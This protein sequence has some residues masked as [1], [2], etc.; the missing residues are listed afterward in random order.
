MAK[1]DWNKRN[2]DQKA[3]DNPSR[4]KKEQNAKRSKEIESGMNAKQKLQRKKA[5]EADRVKT[6]LLPRISKK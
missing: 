2:S 1:Y 6:K 3:L 4:Y 5:L